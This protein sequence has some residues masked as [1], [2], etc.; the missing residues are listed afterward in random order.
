MKHATELAGAGHW[1]AADAVDRVSLDHILRQKRRLRVTAE[2]GSDIMI[3]L[4]GNA[5]MRQGDGLLLEEGGW[6]EVVAAPEKVAIVR[7]DDPLHQAKLAWH[8]GNR[9]TPAE[10]RADCILIAWDS[11]LADML[12]HQGAVV[13][14]AES[15]FQPESGAYH[16]HG[17]HH[18]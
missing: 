5:T 9:H 18:H 16:G 7:F 6:I 17:G 15:V 10:I 12:R 4:P 2:Q 11:V 3:D 8:L 14:E 13:E 1:P